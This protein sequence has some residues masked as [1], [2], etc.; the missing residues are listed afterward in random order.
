M[1]LLWKESAGQEASV[2]IWPPSFFSS[3]RLRQ[4][5]SDVMFLEPAVFF[6]VQHAEQSRVWSLVLG[7]IFS[8]PLPFWCAVVRYAMVVLLGVEEVPQ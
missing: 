7:S 5:L 8:Q 2:V 3:S 1:P 4:R 6:I